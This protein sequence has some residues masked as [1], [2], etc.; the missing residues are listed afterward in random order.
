MPECLESLSVQVHFECPSALSALI[1]S[2]VRVLGDPSASASQSVSQQVIE[3]V[4]KVYYKGQFCDW[5]NMI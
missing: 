3:L 4:Y 5:G 2:S 1:A